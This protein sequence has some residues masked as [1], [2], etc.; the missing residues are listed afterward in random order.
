MVSAY[1]SDAASAIEK[2]ERVLELLRRAGADLNADHRAVRRLRDLQLEGRA[3]RYRG[4]RAERRS[5]AVVV[6]VPEEG[7]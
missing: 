3:D 7:F 1:S 4:E 5:G 2:Y 6:T